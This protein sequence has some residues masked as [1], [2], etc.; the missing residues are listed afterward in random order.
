MELGEEAPEAKGGLDLQAD[1]DL[2]VERR[3]RQGRVGEI[4]DAIDVAVEGVG[5]GAKG[6]GL[7]GAD[8][9][10]DE[11]REALVEGEGEA[12]LDLL[13]TAGGVEVLG[14]DGFG[15]WFAALLSCQP[16]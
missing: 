13:M 11:G 6:R 8:V 9:T 15:G 3:G 14:G 5:E 2:A 10:G 12:A 1:Q 4:D 7:A 16:C